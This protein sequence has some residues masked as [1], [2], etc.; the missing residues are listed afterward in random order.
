MVG[1]AAKVEDLHGDPALRRMD[2]IGDDPV[3]GHIVARDHQGPSRIRST[4]LIGSD[5][6]SD[7]QS[8]TTS[9]ALGIEGRHAFE[10]VRSLLETDMHRPHEDP[11][12]QGGE[13][14]V[15]RLE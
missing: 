6:A 9:S 4:L 3:I 2:G 12:R 13:A 10:S 1:V 7:D 8:S 15:E 5:P 11:V 14:E